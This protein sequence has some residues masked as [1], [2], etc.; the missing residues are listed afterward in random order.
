MTALVTDP[1]QKGD[2]WSEWA[3]DPRTKRNRQR[4]RPWSQM[5]MID[6]SPLRI[7]VDGEL[8]VDGDPFARVP[9]AVELA[10]GRVQGLAQAGHGFTVEETAEPSPTQAHCRYCGGQMSS[11]GSADE[12]LCEFGEVPSPDCQCNW[13]LC[14]NAWLTGQFRG[15]GRPRVQCGAADCKRK[16]ATERKRR[17]RARRPVA[18]ACHV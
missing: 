6:G 13:C 17:S 16:L 2:G 11:A 5:S 7:P 10:E 14:R 9:Y 15:K 18:R 1:D 4:K 12:W 3:G 8:D